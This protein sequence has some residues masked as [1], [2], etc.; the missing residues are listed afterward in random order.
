M[1]TEFIEG[2]CEWLK[3]SKGITKI[4]IEE[5]TAFIPEYTEYLKEQNT[6]WSADYIQCDLCNHK[7]TSVYPKYLDRIECPN[8]NNMVMFEKLD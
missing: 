1:D 8:C 5:L 2:L 7:W 3:E 6:D 4:H